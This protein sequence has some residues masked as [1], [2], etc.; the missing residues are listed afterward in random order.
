[1]YQRFPTCRNAGAHIC[2]L[3]LVSESRHTTCSGCTSSVARL[4]DDQ[5][6]IRSPRV[7]A[8]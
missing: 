1:M 8:T 5:I 6:P 4:V 7:V 2:V 3:R